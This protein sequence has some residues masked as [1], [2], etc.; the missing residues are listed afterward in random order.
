MIRS[1]EIRRYKSHT[2]G[3]KLT[4]YMCFLWGV[5]V[6]WEACICVLSVC[7]CLAMNIP[8]GWNKTFL[9]SLLPLVYIGEG[10]KKGNNWSRCSEDLVNL[11]ICPGNSELS[12]RLVREKRYYP[13]KEKRGFSPCDVWLGVN[14]HLSREITNMQNCMIVT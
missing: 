10:Q 6:G 9:Y 2:E 5:S 14:I 3:M 11:Y 13:V 8:S 1:T 12:W 4:R 7:V